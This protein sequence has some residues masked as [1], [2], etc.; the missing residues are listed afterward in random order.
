MDLISETDPRL[1][2]VSE[3]FDF[4]GTTLIERAALVQ[5]MIDTM[6]NNHGIGLAA[7]QVGINKRVFVMEADGARFPCFNPRIIEVFEETEKSQEGCLS[8]P[9]LRMHVSRHSCIIG[10]FSDVNGNEV[11]RQFKGLAARCFQ[12]ELD[13]LNGVTFDTKVSAMALQ[14]AKKRRPKQRN[15]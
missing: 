8:F 15:K 14:L 11:V 10:Q 9:G 4:Q 13:H 3:D 5:Q 7:P 6:V 12:H 1:K 2:Q